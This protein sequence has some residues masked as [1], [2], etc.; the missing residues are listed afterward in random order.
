MPTVNQ[1]LQKGC[2]QFIGFAGHYFTPAPGLRSDSGPFC[3]EVLVGSAV[4]PAWGCFGCF[5]FFGGMH[6]LGVV[7]ESGLPG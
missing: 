2:L 5:V 6:L 1:I 3:L 7:V 4:Q